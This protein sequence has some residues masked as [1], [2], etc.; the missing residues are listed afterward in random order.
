M[1]LPL[2]VRV[3][4]ALEAFRNLL[5]PFVEANP[6]LHVF[7]ASPQFS[8]FPAWYSSGLGLCLKLLH[9]VVFEN[10]GLPNLHLLPSQVTQVYLR[11]KFF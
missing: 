11:D 9:Q 4:T 2:V 1:F 10:S 6:D 5:Y 7:I 3:T 8:R